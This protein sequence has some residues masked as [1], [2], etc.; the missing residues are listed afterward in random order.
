LHPKPVAHSQLG[1]SPAHALPV[2]SSWTGHASEWDRSG[3]A[4]C[5]FH[6]PA[7]RDSRP[8]DRGEVP[9]PVSTPGVDADGLA[10][11]VLPISTANR[12]ALPC[13]GG[14]VG[15]RRTCTKAPPVTGVFLHLH[16]KPLG[17]GQ[18]GMPPACA[19][20]C[21][22]SRPGCPGRSFSYPANGGRAITVGRI[23]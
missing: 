23:P 9:A 14:K 8:V 4:A 11:S 18:L 7:T 22:E 21:A 15:H 17:H 2:S 6:Q 12:T 13:A 3:V 10:S 1:M 20:P 5:G 19:L 16:P